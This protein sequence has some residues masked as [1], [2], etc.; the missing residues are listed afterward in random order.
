MFH[1]LSVTMTFAICS[2]TPR[3]PETEGIFFIQGNLK[4]R[5]Y[6][7]FKHVTIA[8]LCPFCSSFI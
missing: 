4:W 2:V 7:S 3:K 5:E 1:N 6:F 8:V